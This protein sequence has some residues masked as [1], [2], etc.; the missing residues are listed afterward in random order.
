MYHDGIELQFAVASG[1]KR[2]FAAIS[3]RGLEAANVGKILC[4]R[5][6]MQTGRNPACVLARR[7]LATASSA[8]IASYPLAEFRGLHK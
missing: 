8:V 4:A 6:S 3:S 1:A 7:A 2:S 5:R